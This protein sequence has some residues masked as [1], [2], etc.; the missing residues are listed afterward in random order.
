MCTQAAVKKAKVLLL[1]KAVRKLKDASESGSADSAAAQLRLTLLKALP[2]ALVA[3]QAL[4]NRGITAPEP[5]PRKASQSDD[6][7][8]AEEWERL[9]ADHAQVGAS[10]VGSL[11]GS[12]AVRQQL[13]AVSALAPVAPAEGAAADA[14][15]S[16]VAVAS[17]GPARAGR[18]AKRGRAAEEA[19]GDGTVT[20]AARVAK[21]SAK[22]AVAATVAKGSAKG[23]AAA[24]AP[25]SQPKGSSSVFMS[26]LGD[27][28]EEEEASGGESDDESDG[29]GGFTMGSGGKER[30]P[31]K[32]A[33]NVISK[34]GNR[35]GQ[36][37]RRAILDQAAGGGEGGKGGG[38]GSGKGSGKGAGKGDGKGAGKGSGRGSKG[39]GKGGGGRGGAQGGRG[40]GGSS[41]GGRGGDRAPSA[42]YGSAASGVGASKPQGASSAGALH[43]SWE[44]KKA[45]SAGIQ[46]FQGKRTTFD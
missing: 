10:L 36:R 18:A 21:S 41:G 39:A 24:T 42:S 30:D 34:S 25:K 22:G 29:G 37:Q 45:T 8:S 43:P 38:K 32:K 1:R 33:K 40:R 19:G 35:M 9:R 26:S 13:E 12:A 11:L 3:R 17:S 6:G 23:A 28:S 16:A 46:P 20:K 4:A 14:D 44:A 27:E 7:A 2:P 15:G 31:T 5:T